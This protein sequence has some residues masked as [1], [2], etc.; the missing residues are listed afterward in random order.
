MPSALYRPMR[1]PRIQQPEAAAK[2]PTVCTAPEPAKS[3]A[4]EL[5][6]R[7]AGVFLHVGFVIRT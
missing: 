4:P 1:G 3:I 2:P 6:I 7:L 5:K